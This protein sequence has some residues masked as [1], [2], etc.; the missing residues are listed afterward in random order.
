MAKTWHAEDIKA[1]VRKRGTSLK[2]LATDNGLCESACRASLRRPQPT[3]D[4]VIAEFL[5]EPLHRLWPNRYT[6][7]GERRT[8]RHVRDVN[9]QNRA[10]SHRQIAGRA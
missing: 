10:G 4:K 5:G 2:A 8:V 7:T 1:A 9:T 6:P 3:S